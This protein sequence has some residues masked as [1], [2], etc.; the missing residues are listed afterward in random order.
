[1]PRPR[2]RLGLRLVSLT[3]WDRCPILPQGGAVGK[4][5]CLLELFKRKWRL[6]DE[7]EPASP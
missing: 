5:L 4:N 2:R 7:A 1:M 6:E 3:C